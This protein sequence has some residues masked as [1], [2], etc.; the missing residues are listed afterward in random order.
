MARTLIIE[1]PGAFASREELKSFIRKMRQTEDAGR[2]PL[3]TEIERAEARLQEL[4]EKGN[5]FVDDK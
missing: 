4:E 3:K 2:D 5:P 1:T